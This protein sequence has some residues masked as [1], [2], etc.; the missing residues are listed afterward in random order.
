MSKENYE[1][2]LVFPKYKLLDELFDE[3]ENLFLGGFRD[4][5]KSSVV[6]KNYSGFVVVECPRI[7]LLK[8]EKL[9]LVQSIQENL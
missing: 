6:E 1:R 4:A 7:S 8:V 9:D 2:F 5:V 3:L